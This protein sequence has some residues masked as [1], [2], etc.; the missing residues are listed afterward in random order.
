VIL[1]VHFLA[2]YLLGA[3]PTS[4][5]L[6]RLVR[7]ID[8]RDH[9]SGN[10]G[11]T[12]AWRVLGW[13]IGLPVILIDVAKG[14]VAATVVARLP[15]GPVPVDPQ[16]LAVLCGLAAV[17]GHVFPIYLKFRGGKGV[18]T[19]AGMLVATAPIPV[20]CAAGVFALCLFLSGRV[21]V[22]SISAAWTV[23]ISTLLLQRYAG[24][25]HSTLLIGLTFALAVFIT[26]T[27]RKNLRRLLRGEEPSFPQ[28]QVWKRWLGR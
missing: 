24:I 7:G 16:T 19:A 22:G 9:G 13:R 6:G 11:A 12:N 10:A 21:S 2:S 4:V 17:L 26:I 1:A 15:L 14:A 18:A 27:H 20:G 3:F 5:L 23:P 8:V 25:Q 28:L